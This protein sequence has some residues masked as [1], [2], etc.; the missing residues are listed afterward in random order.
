[1]KVA[2]AGRRKLWLPW[3]A[4]FLAGGSARA[5]WQNFLAGRDGLA[6]NNVRSVLEDGAGALWFGTLA[7]ASR[8]DGL[9]WVT[10]ADSLP[11]PVVLAMCQ[12]SA[13]ALW[14]GTERGGLARFAADRWRH[15]DAGNVLPRNHVLAVF[16]DHAGDVWIGTPG[17]ATRYQPGKDAWTTDSLGLV[18]P[19]VWSFTEDQARTIWAATPRGVSWLDD[20][21]SGWQTFPAGL[22]G[23]PRDSVFAAARDRSGSLW[24]GTTHGVYRYAGGLW[25]RF[26]SDSGLACDTV[27]IIVPDHA[28]GVWLGGDRGGVTHFDGETW[29]I[30]A[31]PQLGIVDALWVDRS[32]NLWIGTRS[33]GLFRYDGVDWH[34]YLS[35]STDCGCTRTSPSSSS[36]FVLGSNSIQGMLQ[37][38][39]G[40]LWFATTCGGAGHLART[41]RWAEVRRRDVPISDSLAT[42][43]ED[44]SGSLW[45]GSR[46]AGLARLDGARAS[47]RVFTRR[48]GLASD[49]VFTVFQ[50]HAGELW[51]GTATGVSRFDGTSWRNSLTGPGGIEV[52]QVVEDRG[53]N[54]WFRTSAGLYR[55]DLARSALTRLG[56]PDLAGDEVTA[57]LCSTDGRIWVGSYSGLATYN[58]TGWT[59][60][61]SF[62]LDS[63]AG[64]FALLED[65]AGRI[66]AGL[67]SGA[68]RY[69]PGSASWTP[70]SQEILGNVGPVMGLFEDDLQ[71]LWLSTSVGLLRFNEDSWHKYDQGDGLA[72]NVIE[73]VL[74]DRRGH[75][76]FG[77]RCGLTRHE[78]DHT[79]PQTIFISS[80]PR[81]VTPSRSASVV[82][83][84]AYGEAADVEFSHS[85]DGGAWSA[86]TSATTWAMEDIPDGFHTFEVR[87]RDW[88]R[89]V[90][91]TPATFTFEVDATPPAAVVSAPR[92]PVT[93]LLEIRGTAADP[94]FRRY[95]IDARVAGGQWSGPGAVAID[96]STTPVTDGTLARWDTRSMPDGRYELRLTV[97]DELGLVGSSQ[98]EVIVDNEAPSADVTS[99][100]RIPVLV[101]GDVYTTNAEVHLYF[102]PHA[103]EQDADVSIAPIDPSPATT[104]ASPS[105][106]LT[107]D[108]EI[109]WS[110]SRL[111]KAAA[112]DFAVPEAAIEAGGSPAIYMRREEGWVRV[113]GTL[114]AWRQNVAAPLAEPGRYALFLDEGTASAPGGISEVRLT[115]RVFS[116]GGVL[117]SREVAISFNLARAASTTVTVY[118][119][120]GR[121]VREVLRGVPLGAGA[122]LV[123]WDGR[124]ADGDIVTAGIYVI[125]VEGNGHLETRTVAVVH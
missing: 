20:T 39:A 28:G 115:P 45:F 6:H 96:S 23:P 59:V 76:W 43:F 7:G 53:G 56:V 105:S 101:G 4:L 3:I 120:A 121:R 103:F 15:F 57:L 29:R 75:L 33:A 107:P 89:N 92:G 118:N 70:Y 2:G 106:R 31:G 125:A 108:Y 114:D 117:P 112:M 62:G 80:V 55:L 46:G 9:R 64:I 18:H 36:D 97:L 77:S 51:V 25:T 99:P 38:H 47:W 109:S 104:G 111:L 123:R 30:P 10:E 79:A 17:G 58:G 37:D 94:R 113:G 22:P 16:A 42:L 35:R 14:F 63:D 32:R 110:A 13:G 124:G 116:P 40:D 44:R 67:G 19:F 73:G 88:S 82:F 72:T 8:Y 78:P 49:T 27:R 100:R 61:T 98:V 119:R 102:P 85:W 50:D 66:W 52:R 74:Q 91:P 1:M 86:W 11:D 69:D 93:G 54:L 34:T 26:S 41:G 71:T 68:A 83:G 21:R 60:F 84:A 122:N 87:T 5:D 81:P 12:D 65:H 24:F 90:D 95:R 48:E